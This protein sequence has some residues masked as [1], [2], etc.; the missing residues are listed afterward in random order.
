MFFR[1]SDEYS[2]LFCNQCI[3]WGMGD[4][5]KLT[6]PFTSLVH[7]GPFTSPHGAIFLL[8]AKKYIPECI[9]INTIFHGL[10]NNNSFIDEVLNNVFVS[11]SFFLHVAKSIAFWRDIQIRAALA[12]SFHLFF[13]PLNHFILIKRIFAWSTSFFA[14]PMKGSPT[15]N[16]NVSAH[17]W[18]RRVL[19]GP[20]SAH[21]R[22]NIL[23][24]FILNVECG[25]NADGN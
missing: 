19:L 5:F 24:F 1:Q 25:T 14:F 23:A 4:Y 6:I 10:P 18:Y 15:K 22:I 20:I 16:R 3:D 2:F 9:K 21:R 7:F 17:V 11:V 8:M 13:D 12:N